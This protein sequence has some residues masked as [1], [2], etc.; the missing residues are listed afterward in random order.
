MR[1]LVPTSVGLC[2]TCLVIALIGIPLGVL[3]TKL[4]DAET[5]VTARESINFSYTDRSISPV[6]QIGGFKVYPVGYNPST[7]GTDPHG[8]P[9]NHFPWLHPGGTPDGADD[10][11]FYSVKE[12][13]LP[14][15]IIVRRTTME[16]PDW[17]T[18]ISDQGY[19]WTYPVGTVA[20]LKF[21]DKE[22]GEFSHHISTKVR[23]GNGI[24]CWD[25][26]E[27]LLTDRVPCC[28]PTDDQ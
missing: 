5:Y 10:S 27:K 2:C 18:P 7:P 19:S 24:D 22:L 17:Y 23:E 9:A 3:D 1:Y 28:G 14:S 11:K 4:V 12:L 16:S 21:F 15:P 8:T 13:K 20:T 25:G 6:Y 26:E